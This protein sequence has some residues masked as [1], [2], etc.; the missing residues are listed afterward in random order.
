MPPQ[1]PD[2]PVAR[3]LTP[4]PTPQRPRPGRRRLRIG[5]LPEGFRPALLRRTRPR[6]RRD[7][8]KAVAKSQ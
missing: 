2:K 1:I 8:L 3:L 6:A 7:S 4:T 5:I